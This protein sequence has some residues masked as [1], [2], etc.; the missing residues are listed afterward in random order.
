M[1]KIFTLLMLAMLSVGLYAEQT[2]S[3]VVVDAKGEP[4]IGASIQAKGTTQGTIS[5]DEYKPYGAS[6]AVVKEV[7]MAG[8]VLKPNGS[9][10]S[11]G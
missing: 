2:V 7:G 11:Q 1:K 9:T 10:I 6:L 8:G 5:D 3:G 4:V